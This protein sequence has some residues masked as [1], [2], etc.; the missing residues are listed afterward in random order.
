[1]AKRNPFRQALRIYRATHDISQWELG[2][3][4]GIDSTKLS[5]IETGKREPT[6]DDLKKFAKLGIVVKIEQ[7]PA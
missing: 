3:K 2:K 6:A 1:M 7:V 4:L 5:M